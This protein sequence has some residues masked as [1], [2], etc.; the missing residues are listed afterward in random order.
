MMFMENDYTD[1]ITVDELCEMMMISRNA[2]YRLLSSG[3]LPC[4]RFGRIWKIPR[5]SVNDYIRA[6][7]FSGKNG[8]SQ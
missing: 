3:E 5:R 8:S 7:S 4:F 6:Q 1:L 2:A